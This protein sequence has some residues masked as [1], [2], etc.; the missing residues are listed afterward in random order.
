M[1]I[2]DLEILLGD[3]DLVLD[4]ALESSSFGTFHLGFLGMLDEDHS[5]LRRIGAVL[6][7]ILSQWLNS[8]DHQPDI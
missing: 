7:Y 3:V 6:P 1:T 4:D 2:C 5:P 8:F